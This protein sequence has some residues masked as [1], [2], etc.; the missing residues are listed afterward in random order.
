MYTSLGL[1]KWP[2]GT[3]PF[4]QGWRL[5]FGPWIRKIP[6]RRA[7]QPT[8]VVLPGESLG[9]RSLAGYSPWGR[10]SR[11][12]LSDWARTHTYLSY[13]MLFSLDVKMNILRRKHHSFPKYVAK[14]CSHAAFFT[15]QGDILCTWSHP[16]VKVLKAPHVLSM[17][18]SHSWQ[19]VSSWVKHVLPP[20]IP[21]S[22]TH[23]PP[24][25]PRQ[26][27]PPAPKPP[28]A[29]QQV[30]PV[31]SVTQSCPTLY[32][33]MDCSMPSLPVHHQLLEFT[34]THVH[35][36]SDAIQPSHPLSS[37]SP[38]AFNLFQHQGLFKWVNSSHQ[39]AKVLE[40]QLQHQF[41]QWIFRTDF[42]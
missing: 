2:S 5:G 35:W 9:P 27:L 36:V 4:C 13:L 14:Q 40:F 38:P 25:H 12:Q 22:E 39:V 37:P 20:S 29:I 8:P 21:G 10:N 6:W 17:S 41:F 31:S 1:P 33:P 11:T 32:D 28:L 24:S 15:V 7:W 23:H 34:Q 19:P 42:L 16:H 18:T 26:I 30:C 3:E